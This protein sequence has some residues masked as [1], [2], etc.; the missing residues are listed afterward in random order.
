MASKKVGKISRSNRLPVIDQPRAKRGKTGSVIQKRTFHS[1]TT[2][3]S[4]KKSSLFNVGS[5]FGQGATVQ[6]ATQTA[7]YSPIYSTDFL[8]LPQTQR[9]KHVYFRHFYARDPIIGRSI[10]IHSELPMSKIRL[11][12]P[13]GKDDDKNQRV[14]HFFEK[15]A[16]HMELF[17]RLLEVAHEYWLMGNVFAFAEYNDKLKVWDR[18]VILDPDTVV[19]NTYPFSSEVSVELVPSSD[20]VD[21]V[22]GGDSGDPD[23]EEKLNFI[24]E[25]IREHLREGKSLPLDTDPYSGSHVSH[26][27]RAKAPY[28]TMGYSI[29]E[30]CLT[31]LVYRDKL[32]QAQTQIASRHMTPIRIVTGPPELSGRD[33]DDLRDQVDQALVDPD[34]SIIA[35]YDI[36]WQEIGPQERILDLSTEME[37]IES[38]LLAGLGITREVLIGEGS[39]SGNRI[40]LEIMNT[41]YLLFREKI[42]SYVENYLFKPIAKANNFIG[43]DEFGNKI[44]LYPALTFTRLSIRDNQD[45]FDNIF[46][47]Y[48][49]GSVSVD[50][51]LE[52]LNID[53]NDSEKKLMRDLGTLKDPTMNEALRGA[54]TEI[55]T[56]LV[57]KTDLLEKIVEN[58]KLKMKE[59]PA[60]EGEEAGEGELGEAGEEA[61]E[62][63]PPEGEGETAPEGEEAAAPPE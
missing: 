45:Y 6:D 23:I 18:L 2:S 42:K 37:Y 22:R 15:M 11:A 34:Y 50:L 24:P 30:R 12:L 61:F 44:L 52:L 4:I 13:K 39:Y 31:N 20:I 59:E 16:E 55:G 28:E 51:I 27:S 62:E 8:E 43:E 46:N 49:K 32:R 60:P 56:Q 9:D 19:V 26:V 54:Y 33:T 58:L 3:S 36:N 29:L 10:D 53:A 38:Q 48:Q 41:Q 25:D 17:E 21:L 40:N 47:L 35:N 63:A 57:E 5:G 1:T 7:L 14:L